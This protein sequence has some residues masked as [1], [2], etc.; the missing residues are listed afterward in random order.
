MQIGA[1]FCAGGSLLTAATIGMSG[2]AF[3]VAFLGAILFGG[4]QFAWGALQW[5]GYQMKSPQGKASHH[6]KVD[7]RVLL[8]SMIAVAAADG[9]LDDGEIIMINE[10]S[11]SLLGEEIGEKTIRNIFD[12]IVGRDYVEELSLIAREVSP[13]GAELA[14]KGAILVGRSDG[15]FDEMESALTTQIASL[16]CVS[17]DRLTQCATEAHQMYDNMIRH[18]ADN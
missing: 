18:Q 15:K 3:V 17:G 5:V 16:L 12:A 10:I 7:V 8:R 2:G 6:L 4:L 11:A 13:A 14:V 1:A 9:R